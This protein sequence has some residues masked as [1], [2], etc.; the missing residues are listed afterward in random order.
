MY[1][2]R[3]AAEMDSLGQHN[4]ITQRI[5]AETRF[6]WQEKLEQH[7]D[8]DDFKNGVVSVMSRTGTGKS[9]VPVISIDIDRRNGMKG[10]CI[11]VPNIDHNL[12]EQH[13][14]K[15]FS[16]LR[17]KYPPA[18]VLESRLEN[19][20]FEILQAAEVHSD[21][22]TMERLNEEVGQIM[23]LIAQ[24]ITVEEPVLRRDKNRRIVLKFG[25]DQFTI[26]ITSL[27]WC[28]ESIKCKCE[29]IPADH[30]IY[31]D[32]FH[33]V[34]TQFGL[35]HG[36]SIKMHGKGHLE[37]F[38]KGYDRHSFDQLARMCQTRK[39]VIISATLD[40][41]ICN[42]LPSYI[43]EF[44]ILN[45]VV[46]HQRE[47][48]SNPV[49][50]SSNYHL[51]KAKTMEAYTNGTR[52]VLFCSNSTNLETLKSEL[53]TLGVLDD[54]I[55]SYTTNNAGKKKFDVDE[56]RN[57][58]VNIFIN[59]GSTGMDVSDIGLV[60]IFR[61]LNDSASCRDKEDKM[62]SNFAS[63]VI[64]RIRNGGKVFWQRDDID[65]TSLYDITKRNYEIPFDDETND[66]NLLMYSLNTNS[67]R[68]PFERHVVRQ[69]ISNIIGLGN[70]FKANETS[71]K[72]V[73]RE[74]FDKH[75]DEIVSFND[76]RGLKLGLGGAFNLQD[77]LKQ[78]YA[79][80]LDDTSMYLVLEKK[81]MITYRSVFEQCV[82]DDITNLMFSV[83]DN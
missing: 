29:S 36:K 47:Q 35:V 1:H 15:Y 26:D 33:K 39:V 5:M 25:D 61:E 21:D 10:M 75:Y 11:L 18:D 24:E 7:P 38:A 71:Q 72:T 9:Y 12:V 55:Y 65:D 80:G 67:D 74:L 37:A 56:I 6:D 14:E 64:G 31:I 60:M 63:Q 42:E 44:P 13:Y 23:S 59:K 52:S 28:S 78:W 62:I 4:F 40:D 41:I 83:S 81:M 30:S 79:L 20:V 73:K 45:F 34:Q 57:H 46:V 43:G 17:D 16:F 77:F 69:C 8:Y 66:E 49:I 54:D 76:S 58:L 19:K 51:M 82:G 68:T 50:H 53:I 48:I 2:P 3:R 70:K 22:A 32:E 27:P